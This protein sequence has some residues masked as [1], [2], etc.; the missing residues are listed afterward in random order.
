MSTPQQ[1]LEAAINEQVLQVDLQVG[2]DQT[3]MATLAPDELAHVPFKEVHLAKIKVLT[4]EAQALPAVVDNKTMAVN[5]A[6]LTKLVGIRTSIDRHRKALFDPVNRLKKEVDAYLGTTADAGLQ[7]MIKALERPIEARKAEWEQKK[8]AERQAKLQAE[9]ERKDAVAK[10]LIDAGMVFDGDSFRAGGIVFYPVDVYL[11]DE[12]T[13]QVVIAEQVAPVVAKLKAE[14]EEAERLEKERRERKAAEQAEEN[15][16]MQR[17][18]ER[19]RIEREK[20]DADRAAI[21]AERKELRDTKNR[22][23]WQ[24]IATLGAVDNGGRVMIRTAATHATMAYRID[25]LA[26]LNDDE[27]NAA[28]TY[29]RTEKVLAIQRQQEKERGDRLEEERSEQIRPL[30][31]EVD[32]AGTWTLGNAC[33]TSHVLRTANEAE[34]F[35]VVAQF[36]AEQERMAT[37]VEPGQ[38]FEGHGDPANW[39]A[40]ID[41]PDDPT[42]LV[43]VPVGVIPTLENGSPEYRL[44]IEFT[45]WLTTRPETTCFGWREPSY[46]PA[47]LIVEFCKIKGFIL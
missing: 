39:A 6:M 20:L 32:G 4:E 2:I 13:L 21:D 12:T 30:G 8:E 28:K 41:A 24:E 42:N 27:W 14:A 31:A 18:F 19:Q 23:R 15:A 44:L 3:A 5:Q 16:R 45:E 37:A 1:P 47:D 10:R 11:W 7:G 43:T 33:T 9:Q 29:T 36:K 17:E 40:H 25:Q 35:Q 34:W 46:L 38:V 22:L 26:D